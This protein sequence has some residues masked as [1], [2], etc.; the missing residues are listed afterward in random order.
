LGFAELKRF[1]SDNKETKLE[2]LAHKQRMQQFE[3]AAVGYKSPFSNS[4]NP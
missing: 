3:A 2:E 4:S 1:S